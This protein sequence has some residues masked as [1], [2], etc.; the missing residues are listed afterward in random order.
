[1]NIPFKKEIKRL[2]DENDEWVEET[3]DIFNKNSKYFINLVPRPRSSSKRTDNADKTLDLDECF[4][5]WCLIRKYKLKNILELGTRFGT[6]TRVIRCAQRTF[7]PDSQTK[8]YSCDVNKEY[9]YIHP[10][11]F[12]F[13]HRDA[14]G[15]FPHFLKENQIDCIHNDAH[16]Y[17]LIKLSTQAAIDTKIKIMT[18]HD[19][20]RPEDHPRGSCIK[21]SFFL[22]EKEKLEINSNLPFSGIADYGHWERHVICELFSK[23]LLENNFVETEQYK[24]QMFCSLFGLGVVVNK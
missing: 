12:E 2:L 20:S 15:L 4:V 3:Y 1:M 16:P 8:L 17:D 18:Y 22:S 23:E 21:N 24:I 14:K 6:S 7:F 10:D 9:R 11:E 13:I 5:Y 19:V